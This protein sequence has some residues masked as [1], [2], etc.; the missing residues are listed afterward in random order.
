MQ[1]GTHASKL[2]FYISYSNPRPL[3]LALLWRWWWWW[4]VGESHQVSQ[5]LTPLRRPKV[6]FASVTG[7]VRNISQRIRNRFLRLTPTDP[8]AQLTYVHTAFCACAGL[9]TDKVTQEWLSGVITNTNMGSS[10]PQTNGWLDL[11][12]ENQRLS[13]FSHPLRQCTRLLSHDLAN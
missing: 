6:T 7:I 2:S 3:T 13:A 8:R 12:A 11:S 10:R 5:H 1:T 4:W 9:C